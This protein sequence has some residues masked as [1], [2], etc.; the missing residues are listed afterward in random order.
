MAECASLP[1]RDVPLVRWS[2]RKPSLEEKEAALRGTCHVARC[3][4]S[5][6]G[7]APA[8]APPRCGSTPGADSEP[9]GT[10]S[11]RSGDVA[12]RLDQPGP[13]FVNVSRPR[14]AA[15]FPRNDAAWF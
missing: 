2:E 9:A 10:S 6:D 4:A 7:Y 1:A 3:F 13:V 14:A 15:H 12:P 5:T 11:L 8:P